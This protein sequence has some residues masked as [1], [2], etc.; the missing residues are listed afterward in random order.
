MEGGE[1][2]QFGP[3]DAVGGGGAAAAVGHL[4]M[5]LLLLTIVVGAGLVLLLGRQGGRDADVERSR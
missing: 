4:R 1:S 3:F 2:T 5:L